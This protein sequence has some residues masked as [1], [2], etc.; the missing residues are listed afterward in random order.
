VWGFQFVDAI[1]IAVEHSAMSIELAAARTNNFDQEVGG[2]GRRVSAFVKIVREVATGDT[3]QKW[4]VPGRESSAVTTTPLA[5]NVEP[6][7]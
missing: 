5:S 1:G 7:N 3:N 6:S 2:F 4:T